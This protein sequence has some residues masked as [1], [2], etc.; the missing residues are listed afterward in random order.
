[1]SAT[2]LVLCLLT[3]PDA[4]N[5]P[6]LWLLAPV[7]AVHRLAMRRQIGPEWS[8]SPDLL[9]NLLATLSCS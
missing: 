5:G 4:A 7:E 8:Q 3:P 1:M 6:V 2:G 9:G